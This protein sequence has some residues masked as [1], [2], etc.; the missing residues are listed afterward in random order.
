MASA[1]LLRYYNVDLMS[2]EVVRKL[3]ASVTQNAQDETVS[4]VDSMESV[5]KAMNQMGPESTGHARRQIIGYL[6]DVYFTP[7][8]QISDEWWFEMHT[9]L[10]KLCIVSMILEG[11]N[12]RSFGVVPNE[13]DIPQ[14]LVGIYTIL[15]QKRNTFPQLR[16]THLHKVCALP[17]EFV[18]CYTKN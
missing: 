3:M 5:R 17:N 4:F 10:Q 8:D 14:A 9:R 13:C 16:E 15:I 7:Q 2:F 11:D 1:K 18:V 6:N 12:L